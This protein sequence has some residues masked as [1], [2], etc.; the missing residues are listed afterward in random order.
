V[1]SCRVFVHLPANVYNWNDAHY[2]WQRLEK[3]EALNDCV[4]QSAPTSL[5]SL[6]VCVCGIGA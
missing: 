6:C 3:G 2:R 5:C 1:A 4:E